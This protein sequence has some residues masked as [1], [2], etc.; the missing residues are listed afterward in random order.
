[1]YKSSN[2][3]RPRI[4]KIFPS[5]P[6]FP[7]PPPPPHLET[8][9]GEMFKDTQNTQQPD[10]GYWAAHNFCKFFCIS[11][12]EEVPVSAL[13]PFHISSPSTTTLYFEHW[14]VGGPAGRLYAL[15]VWE[16]QMKTAKCRAAPPV[17]TEAQLKRNS[18][19]H[20][21]GSRLMLK[22]PYSQ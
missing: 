13:K 12:R 22:P 21:G 20:L 3:W 19:F 7:A 16:L 9:P 10:I 6:S 18:A 11:Q 14:G 8:L 5:L 2:L 15:Q 4:Y 1:M 17:H